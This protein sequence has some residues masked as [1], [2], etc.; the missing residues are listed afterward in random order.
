MEKIPID[1]IRENIIP[2]TYNT[3]RKDLCDDIISFSNTKKYLLELYFNRWNHTFYY[4][5]NA[6]LNWL[7]NDI[8]RF[9]NDDIALITGLTSNM[10]K[11]LRRFYKLRNKNENHFIYYC[12]K[13]FLPSKL[14]QNTNPIFYINFSLGMLNKDERIILV[15]FLKGLI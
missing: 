10:K 9:L 5:E 7:E 6:H 4:E 15:N 1:V 12:S 11:Y 14:K 3:Q 2:Y 8:F 13:N